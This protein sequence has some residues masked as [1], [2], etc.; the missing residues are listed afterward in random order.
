MAPMMK[1]AVIE[2]RYRMQMRLWSM[3]NSHE[4]SVWAS[5]R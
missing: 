2:M 4:R 5:W 1:N 3:V